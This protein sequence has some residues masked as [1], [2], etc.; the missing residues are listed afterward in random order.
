MT[1]H[2]ILPASAT[3]EMAQ[4]GR[5]AYSGL[6]R[7]EVVARIYAHIVSAAPEFVTDDAFFEGMARAASPE[8]WE[9]I[10]RSPEYFSGAKE[11]S[12]SCARAVWTFIST[13][14][15]EGM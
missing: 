2:R 11:K 6:L 8:L 15:K 12:L 13:T 10:D 5:N 1:T 14:L 4:A 9:D 7:A 3:P